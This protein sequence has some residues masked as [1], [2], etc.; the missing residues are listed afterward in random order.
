[1]IDAATNDEDIEGDED[2]ANYAH[3]LNDKSDDEIFILDHRMVKEK[4]NIQ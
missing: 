3:S 2:D 1:M 4:E